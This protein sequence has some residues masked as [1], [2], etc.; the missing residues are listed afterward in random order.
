MA[1]GR[2]GVLRQ[3][4]FSIAQVE[5]LSVTDGELLNRY[6]RNNDQDAFET[7]VNRHSAMVLGVCRRTLPTVQDAEDACHLRAG[8]RTPAT[9]AHLPCQGVSFATCTLNSRRCVWDCT[10]CRTRPSQRSYHER[11]SIE[12]ETV[13]VGSCCHSHDRI[14]ARNLT[15]LNLG[16]TDITDVGLNELKNLKKLTILNLQ[17]TQVTD[18]GL[19]VLKNLE[20]LTALYLAH[21]KVTDVGLKELKDVKNLCVLD[22]DGTKITDAGIEELKALKKLTTLRLI[23]TPVTGADL[24]E[25]KNLTYLDLGFTKVTDAGLEELKELKKLTTLNLQGT[26]VTGTGLKEFRYLTHLD[27]EKTQTSRPSRSHDLSPI[28]PSRES[29]SRSPE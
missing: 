14:W 13:C 21:P 27:L 29:R 5:K 7:L 26:R 2:L 16:N 28:L 9:C 25:L 15:L 18:M 22:L 6:S 17:G 3:M 11:I 4:S 23:G 1:G 19:K 20:S 10:G 24:K 12:D 8:C